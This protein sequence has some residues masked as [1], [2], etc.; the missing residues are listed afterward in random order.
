MSANAI[1][2]THRLGQKF[3]QGVPSLER[4][5]SDWQGIGSCYKKSGKLLV[6]FLD[7]KLRTSEAEQKETS[8][9]CCCV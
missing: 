3:S 7:I 9:R 1:K 4:Q 2:Q 5:S 8:K 6:K